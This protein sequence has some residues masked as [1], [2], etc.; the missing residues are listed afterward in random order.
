MTTQDPNHI[1][2]VPADTEIDA[3]KATIANVEVI[4]NADKPNPRK[5][6]P[7]YVA[8]LDPDERQQAEARL[9]R[10]IDFRLLPVLVVMYIL[11]YL[12]RNNIVCISFFLS[13]RWEINRAG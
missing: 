13:W 11:N 4:T 3:A 1:Q 7:A 6:A 12:D 2:Q 5:E 10:K 9:V 8:A